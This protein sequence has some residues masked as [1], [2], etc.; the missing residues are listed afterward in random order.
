MAFHQI[1]VI[2]PQHLRNSEVRFG[3]LEDAWSAPLSDVFAVPGSAL[4]EKSKGT[5]W[6]FQQGA[7]PT[8]TANDILEDLNL[9]NQSVQSSFVQPDSQG[10][11]EKSAAFGKNAL[12]N[13]ARENNVLS[14]E[15]RVIDLLEIQRSR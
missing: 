12:D 11:S 14:I 3:N 6:L 4:S 9:E 5:N 13:Y 15:R 1:S 10:S 7:N 2:G 8:T